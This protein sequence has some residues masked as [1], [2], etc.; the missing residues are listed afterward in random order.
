V[1]TNI[2][3]IILIYGLDGVNANTYKAERKDIYQ[4]A[5]ELVIDEN[6]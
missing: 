3:N 6:R 4:N 1:S 2:D 5:K